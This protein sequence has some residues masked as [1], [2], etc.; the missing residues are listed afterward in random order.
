MEPPS[1]RGDIRRY[2]EIA[3]EQA[4]HGEQADE[5]AVSGSL[6][7]EDRG[8]TERHTP[9]GNRTGEDL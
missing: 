4:D 6:V 1:A 2:P 5:V 3:A 9:H 7:V 8:L